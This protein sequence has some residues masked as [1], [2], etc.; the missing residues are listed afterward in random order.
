MES[1]GPRVTTCYLTLTGLLSLSQGLVPREGNQ[2]RRWNLSIALDTWG[3]DPHCARQ[4]STAALMFSIP[5]IEHPRTDPWF[6]AHDPGWGM[7]SGVTTRPE[8]R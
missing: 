4:A 2:R 5:V 8:I 1:G 7:T 6:S 3:E